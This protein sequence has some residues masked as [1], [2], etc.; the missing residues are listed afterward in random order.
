MTSLRYQCQ[1]ASLQAGVRVYGSP[2]SRTRVIFWASLPGYELPEYPQ[3]TH[4]FDGRVF[5]SYYQNRRPAPHRCVTIQDCLVDLPSFEWI[6]PHMINPETSVQR[7]DRLS[8]DKNI[9][10]CSSLEELEF[11]GLEEQPYSFKPLSEYQ[12]RLQRFTSNKPLRNHT[13]L[14]RPIRDCERCC[15]VPLQPGATYKDMPKNLQPDFLRMAFE[16]SHD[17]QRK[18]NYNGRFGGQSIS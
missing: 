12:R 3:A 2:S 10:Q 7:S 1:Y 16:C 6:N 8:R 11:V 9:T 5:K 17:E 13:T 4:I 15:N 14:R 18:I